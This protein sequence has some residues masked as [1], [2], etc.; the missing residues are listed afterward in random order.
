MT[1]TG[2]P[3]PQPLE[4]VSL[5]DQLVS[6]L[7]SQIVNRQRPPGSRLP[8]EGELAREFGVSRPVIREGLSRLRERGYLQT[9]NG[10]GTFVQVPGTE[11]LGDSLLRQIRLGQDEGFDVDRLYEARTAI[12]VTT[13]RLAAE[14]ADDDE[15]ARL[16][17]LLD[18]MRRS[19]DDP[20]AFTDADVGFHIT[21]SNAARNP[22]L[23]LMLQPL[24]RIIIEGVL[25]SS[26]TRPDG[27]VDGIRMHTAV[28][29]AIERRDPDG[30]AAAMATHLADSHRSF[31]E[32]VLRDLPWL[33]HPRR[34]Q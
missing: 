2:P 7:E 29:A 24:A 31:P 17:G 25:S 34:E 21:V 6:R 19:P 12:E 3:S 4:R 14:R 32:S 11:H 22:F 23:S 30:A 13:A 5:L 27:V 20:P 9:V 8:A 28:L 26:T 15:I 18:Q 33:V 16:H 10:R 1:P